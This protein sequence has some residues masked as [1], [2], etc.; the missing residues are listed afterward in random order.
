MDKLIATIGAAFAARYRI[1][2]III[3]GILG[4]GAYTYTSL[5]K[6]DG[7]PPIQFPVAT[8]S[9]FYLGK[10][11]VAVETELTQPVVGAIT[12]IPEIEKI[13]TSS[14][15]QFSVVVVQFKE[16]TKTAAGVKLLEE[17]LQ[18]RSAG[19]PAGVK[20]EVVGIN[21]SSV[22]GEN[23]LLFSLATSKLDQKQ[24]ETRATEL[25]VR[26]EPLTDVMSAQVQSLYSTFTN[27]VTGVTQEVQT[28]FNRVGKSTINDNNKQELKFLPAVS[29]GIKKQGDVGAVELSKRVRAEV[30][31]FQDEG[32][33]TDIEV[34][35]GGDSAN[36]V[37]EQIASLE[38][39]TVLGLLTITLVLFLF[40]NWRASIATALFM[41]LVLGATFLTLYLI[42]YTLNV[43]SLFALILVLGLFVDDGI[44]VV[45]A[46]DHYKKQGMKG[47]AAVTIALR[48]VGLADIIG[49]LT[50][51]IVFIPMLFIS[52]VLG[53]FIRLIPITVM[54][55]LSISLLISL[56]LLPF[57]SNVLIPT[58]KKTKR[59]GP[60]YYVL[61]GFSL[62][63]QWLGTQVSRFVDFY[64]RRKLVGI[65]VVLGSLALVVFGFSF[66]SRLGFS[67]FPE[68]KDANALSISIGYPEG[69]DLATAEKVALEVE[70]ELQANYSA[71]IKEVD[72]FGASVRGA[73]LS[74]NLTDLNERILTAPEIAERLNSKFS[75]IKSAEIKVSTASVGPPTSD[76]PF[77]LQIYSQEQS[78]LEQTGAEL[79][80]YLNS[81]IFSSA[82]KD[83]KVTEVVITNLLNIATQDGKRYIEVA[84]KFDQAPDSAGVIAV[85]DQVRKAF[86][87]TRLSD[88]GLDESAIAFDQGFESDNQEAFGSTILAF[89]IAILLM[90]GLLLLRFN[91]FS[92]PILIFMAIIFSSWGV[93]PGLFLTNNPMSFFVL[94]GA[95]ALAGIAVNNTIMLVDYANQERQAGK[96][97]R[98]SIVEA[99]KLRFRPLVTTTA[100]TV[101]GLLPLA[102]SDPFWESL[103]FTIVFGL[104]ASTFTVI[105]A[106]PAYYAL[107]EKLRAW[108]NKLLPGLI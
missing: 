64:L 97:I 69:T 37:N 102:L 9:S 66:A 106:F 48:R 60:L 73:S 94:I 90:Y 77:K 42:G 71:E 12:A 78:K 4:I 95:I 63:V 67:I 105:F 56:T 62:G 45:E 58:F 46:I 103:A 7:F 104:L 70:A 39:N 87:E 101:A 81:N 1:T 107:T 80:N 10:D 43:I 59:Q 20:P 99:T 21:A 55:A 31:K 91:S 92:Q 82:G 26:L 17:A 8:I 14:N 13:S 27:P 98:E 33:L 5:L 29:I 84:A 22:D 2:I 23:D 53:E 79:K 28:S 86:T 15:P 65:I 6:R 38:E 83:Y 44:V 18:A 100:T 35:Y 47:L 57:L 76:F 49:T 50:T 54:L 75:E 52:G 24:L 40:I 36:T 32:K 74:L 88:L 85:T 34:S 93:F 25:A 108:K 96:S 51:L 30:S 11:A 61:N 72:Y 89:G 41:P 16:D 3:I 19:L 68:P